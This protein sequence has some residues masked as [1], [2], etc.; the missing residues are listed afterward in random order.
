MESELTR[1][2]K[3]EAA[4]RQRTDDGGRMTEDMLKSGKADKLKRTTDDR[5]QRT[6]ALT[7]AKH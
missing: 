6:E 1:R 2:G 4:R 3:A 5:G 7:W